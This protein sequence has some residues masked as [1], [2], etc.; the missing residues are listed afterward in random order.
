MVTGSSMPETDEG[1]SIGLTTLTGWRQFVAPQPAPPALLPTDRLRAPTPEERSAY[2]EA[3]IEHHARLGIVATPVI[4]KV[5]T[6][7]RRLTYL[8]RHAISG[9]C[10]LILAAACCD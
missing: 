5:I 3:R 1:T 9:R 7:G 8:N 10:G 4:R 2:D 6:E